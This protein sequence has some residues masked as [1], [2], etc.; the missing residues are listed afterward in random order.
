MY[1]A[2]QEPLVQQENLL[3]W[4][5]R[6]DFSALLTPLCIPLQQL[7]VRLHS[8]N[9]QDIPLGGDLERVYSQIMYVLLTSWLESHNE[10]YT[11]LVYSL[12]NYIH[13][14]GAELPSHVL[15]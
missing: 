8:L 9:H 13:G 12:H 3:V 1:V 7:S 4:T 14:F 6:W 5:T 2:C 11:V 15:T 10:E